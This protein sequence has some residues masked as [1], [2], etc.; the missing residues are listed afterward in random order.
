MI[1]VRVKLPT[2]VFVEP[3]KLIPQ[4]TPDFANA[5]MAAVDA[6]I[7]RH[8]GRSCRYTADQTGDGIFEFEDRD[9][10]MQFRLRYG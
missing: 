3:A 8:Y 1:E 2:A 4:T 7:R 5:F 9:A 6:E 10:A